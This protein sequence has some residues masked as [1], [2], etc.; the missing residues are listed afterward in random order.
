MKTSTCPKTRRVAAALL[1]LCC[2]DCNG[3]NRGPQGYLAADKNGAIFI[4]FTEQRGQL[5]GQLQTFGV[6]GRGAKRT[7]SKNASFTGSRDDSNN[8]SLRFAGFFTDHTVTGTLSGDTLSLVLPQSNGTLATVEFRKAS[9][10]EYNSEVEKLKKQVAEVNA[11]AAQAQAERTHAEQVRQRATDLDSN[12]Q[13][14]YESLDEKINSLSRALKFKE[15]LEE[16]NKHWREMQE[17]EK[18]FRGKA[19][20]HPLDSNQLNE[21]GYA[22]QGLGYDQQHIGYDRQNLNYVIKDANREISETREAIAALRN[23]WNE[24]QSGRNTE[25]GDHLRSEINES[26]IADMIGRAEAAVRSAENAIGEADSK[27]R[28]IEQQVAEVYKR[29]QALLGKLRANDQNN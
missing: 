8:V 12:I 13:R 1:L 17:H 6:E 19:A 27:A 14:A 11:A 21:I 23:A 10:S 7:D 16:F 3:L 29:S 22:L 18:G 20:V 5:S 15:P 2:L 28:M 26:R 4:Q 9:V 24:L 25:V